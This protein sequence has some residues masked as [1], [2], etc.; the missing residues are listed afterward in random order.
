M[1][2]AGRKN[3]GEGRGQRK[4]LI[5]QCS[6]LEYNE[7]NFKKEVDQHGDEKGNEPVSGILSISEGTEQEHSESIQD[8]PGAISALC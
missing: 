4:N 1:K 5:S 7:G 8:R 2:G 6:Y 3:V